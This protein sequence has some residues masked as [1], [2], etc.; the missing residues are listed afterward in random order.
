[1]VLLYTGV[2]VCE[3]EFFSRVISIFSFFLVCIKSFVFLLLISQHVY[4]P[5]NV[6]SARARAKTEKCGAENKQKN[7]HYA[8]GVIEREQKTNTAAVQAYCARYCYCILF[9]FF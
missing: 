2:C 5:H 1:M 3:C 4:F 7:A 8:E 6:L 9:I